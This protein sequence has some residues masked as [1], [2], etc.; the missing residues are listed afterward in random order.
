MSFNSTK[1]LTSVSLL[2]A[3]CISTFG[4]AE[5]AISD[6]PPYKLV[7]S[8]EYVQDTIARGDLSALDMQKYLL[9]A[10]DARLK[11]STSKDFDDH[12]NVNAALIYTMSGGNSDTLANLV[13]NDAAG[14][15]DIRVTEA[16]RMYLNG[17]S[18]AAVKRLEEMVPEYKTSEIG[19]YLALVAANSL[20]STNPKDALKY[21]DWARLVAPGT[22]IE[23]TALRRSVAFAANAELYDKAVGYAK[24]YARRFTL[25]PYAGQFADIFV[26]LAVDHDK[27][28][29][30]DDV[31]G[32]LSQMEVS[33]QRE[34]YLRMARKAALVGKLELAKFCADQAKELLDAKSENSA[35]L[36]NLYSALAKVP[37]ADVVDAMNA[38]AA[39]PDD[40]LSEKDRKLRDAAKF[41]ANE[42]ITPPIPASLTQADDAKLLVADGMQNG[43]ISTDNPTAPAPLGA[44]VPQSA[45]PPAP[46]PPKAASET[47]VTQSGKQSP[48]T[49]AATTKQDAPSPSEIDTF[50]AGERAKLDEIDAMLK[51]VP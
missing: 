19:P 46:P 24:R 1:W 51:K 7:R 4:N 25:S 17:K 33:R 40:K 49:T 6:L 2:V 18:D 41:I 23:E 43:E 48:P 45:A 26:S 16:L 12:R 10:I 34:V 31:K 14:H 9:S 37:S 13:F 35:I 29:S 39:I 42:V 15:F 28:I 21:F 47:P 38:I 50:V 11:K 30:A 32:V 44:Q 22:I 8:L 5:D 36:A 20:G 27:K 3:V